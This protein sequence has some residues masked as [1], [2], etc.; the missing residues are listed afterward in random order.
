MIQKRM[1]T[2][3]LN[4]ANWI[5]YLILNNVTDKYYI[6]ITGKSLEHRWNTHV[7]NATWGCDYYFS[8]AIRKYGKQAFSLFTIAIAKTR[9][10]AEEVEKM[11]IASLQSNNPEFGYNGTAGGDGVIANAEVIKK[12]ALAYDPT[13][14]LPP[15]PRARKDVKTEEIASLYKL[16]MTRTNIAAKFG[17]ASASVSYRLRLAG[18]PPEYTRQRRVS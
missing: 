15:S 4:S 12:R 13:P 8:K 9:E 14:N 2:E 7:Y 16:G 18:I 1:E 10:A 5:I 17:L 3:N 11:M 6:G